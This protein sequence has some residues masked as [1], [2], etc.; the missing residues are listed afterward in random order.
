MGP[1]SAPPGSSWNSNNASLTLLSQNRNRESASA[2]TSDAL[3]G[4]RPGRSPKGI[5]RI[6]FTGDYYRPMMVRLGP[7]KAGPYRCLDV[8]ASHDQ[9]HASIGCRIHHRPGDDSDRAG[10]RPAATG[11]QPTGDEM[12][13]RSDA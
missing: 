5:G 7:A 11:A 9:A 8:G 12:D 4:S 10:P 3:Y 6:F 1:V 13:G 2:N